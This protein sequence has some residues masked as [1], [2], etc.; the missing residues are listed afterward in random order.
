MNLSAALMLSRVVAMVPRHHAA[1]TRDHTLIELLSSALA[2]PN[3]DPVI[4][5]LG[6]LAIH[7]YGL[8][9]VVG[10]LFGWWYAKRLLTTPKLWRDGKAP[11]GPEIIDDLLVYAALGIVL[12]GRIGYILFYDFQRYLANPFDIIAIWQGG[13]SFHGGFLGTTLQWCFW[14][15]RA[16]SVF[17]RCS[18][19]S[20]PAHR[21]RSVWSAAP[22]SS[23]PSCGAVQAI[24]H[25]R[26]FFPMA[27]PMRVIRASSMR[28]FSKDWSCSSFCGC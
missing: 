17:G 15:D 8:G 14:R 19:S 23:I 3:I 9:Y 25:G 13:M 28:P 7:W 5:R 22:I 26:W 1:A 6:P 12:G 11:F 18:T 16:G 27:D 20:R 21:L 4:V 24:C 10:I 2:F